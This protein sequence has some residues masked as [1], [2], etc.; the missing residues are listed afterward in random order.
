MSKAGIIPHREEGQLTIA[1]A[2][3]R[4]VDIPVSQSVANALGNFNV[5]RFRLSAIQWLVDNNL[6][7][8]VFESSSF[9]S[10][11]GFANHEEEAALWQ[12]YHSVA[13]FV[14][15]M[16]DYIALQAIVEPSQAASKLHISFNG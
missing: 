7:I 12:S 2:V 9:R 13:R 3:A 16:Y 4:G 6:P 14:L 10:I 5:Q 8:R 15:R 1:I 11:I